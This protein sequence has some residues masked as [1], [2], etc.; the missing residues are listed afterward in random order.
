M[1]GY[2]SRASENLDSSELTDKWNPKEPTDGDV[3]LIPVDD[4]SHADSAFECKQKYYIAHMVLCG[5]MKWLDQ[6]QF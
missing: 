5:P 4:S 3:V 6:G 1:G 2:M